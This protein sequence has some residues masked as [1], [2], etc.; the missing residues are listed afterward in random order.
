MC[1]CFTHTKFFDR[2]HNFVNHAPLSI[3]AHCKLFGHLFAGQ[4]NAGTLNYN[5][6]KLARNAHRV[7][8][9]H[10]SGRVGHIHM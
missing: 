10:G 7:A 6:V 9:E 1:M 4:G 3:W 5:V 8:S 2:A